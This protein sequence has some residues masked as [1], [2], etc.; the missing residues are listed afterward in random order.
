MYYDPEEMAEAVERMA[1]ALRRT[2]VYVPEIE[3]ASEYASRM[4]IWRQENAEAREDAENS[5]I[6]EIGNLL[7]DQAPYTK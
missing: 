2:P 5:W 6:S 4:R 3:S 7:R 1:K